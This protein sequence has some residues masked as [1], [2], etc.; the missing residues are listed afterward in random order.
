MSFTNAQFEAIK[1]IYDDRRMSN[2]KEADNRRDYVEKTI[3]GFRELADRMVSLS[4]DQ[5]KKRAMG[6]EVSSDEYRR[7]YSELADEKK[8]LLTGASLPEDYLDPIYTCELCKDTGYIDGKPCRCLKKMSVSMLYSRSNIDSYL[9]S[10]DFSMVSD[11]YYE[12]DE[13]VAFKDT[14]ANA[15]NFVNNFDNDFKNL[16]IYGTVGSGK[17][18]ISACIARELI[19]K[20]YTV[21]YFSATALMELFSRYSFDHEKKNEL[22]SDHAQI[23]ECDLLIIDDL[24]TEQVNSFTI[25]TLFNC[26]NERFLNRR[27]TIISTNLSPKA[28]AQTYTERIYSRLVGSYTFCKLYGPDIR[29]KTKFDRKDSQ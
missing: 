19:E 3:P 12:G 11:R 16:V 18:L 4:M 5:A 14:Y 13:L 29:F 27:S 1:R 2:Q 21:L 22:Y 15:L 25:T 26:L 20:E 17:S 24:G 7:I 6:E 8:R 28:I 9:K 10:V 23:F